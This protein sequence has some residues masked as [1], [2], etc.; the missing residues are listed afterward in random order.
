VVAVQQRG[1]K[2]AELLKM[3]TGM[4]EKIET[5]IQTAGTD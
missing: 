2:G 3:V 4:R 1:M 5:G